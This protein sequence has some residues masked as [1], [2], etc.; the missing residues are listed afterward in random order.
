MPTD[1]LPKFRAGQVWQCRDQ[2]YRARISTDVREDGEYCVAN[3]FHQC[4]HYTS[5]HYSRIRCSRDQSYSVVTDMP[6]HGDLM[7]LLYCPS[8]GGEPLNG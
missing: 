6:H 2:E 8:W 5:Y 1:K 4:V 7:A 3:L